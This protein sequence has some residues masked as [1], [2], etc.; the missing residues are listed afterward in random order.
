MFK[1][2]LPPGDLAT[3]QVPY[4]V[5]YDFIVGIDLANTAGASG[6]VTVDFQ[7]PPSKSDWV[8]VGCPDP[9]G[10]NNATLLTVNGGQTGTSPFGEGSG[11]AYVLTAVPGQLIVTSFPNAGNGGDTVFTGMLIGETVP[12]PRTGWL[13]LLGALIAGG[14]CVMPRR[15]RPA[16]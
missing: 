10:G 12:E 9:Y 3:G 1:A 7:L 13:V 15:E 2:I 16:R 4:S 11:S 14:A 8:V 5:E 6:E